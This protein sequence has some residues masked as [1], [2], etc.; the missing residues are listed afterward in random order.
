MAVK[1]LAETDMSVKE[2]SERLHYNN[3]QNFIRSFRKT[4]GITPGEYRKLRKEQA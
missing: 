4:E 3:S 1:W 2:I